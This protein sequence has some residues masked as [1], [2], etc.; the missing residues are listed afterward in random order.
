MLD[1][2]L[3]NYAWR[4]DIYP[5]LITL[6]GLTLAFLAIAWWRRRNLAEDERMTFNRTEPGPKMAVVDKLLMVLLVLVIIGAGGVAVY[7][8]IK[9]AKPYSE[10]YLLG[11]EGK[12]AD[13]P[14]SLTVGQQ[15]QLTL[16]LNN[17]EKQAI[18]YIIRISQ[19]DSST[20]IDGSEQNEIRITLANGQKQSYDISFSFNTAGSGKE[21]GFDLYKGDTSEIY[22]RTYLRV[23]VS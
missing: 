1:S 11:A 21:L 9:N 7:V 16:V 20:L 18:S 15:G 4:I 12:A 23:D 22:L 5:L 13:Y 6:E 3:L 10:F 14:Q 8:G 2:L 17:H 19:Q